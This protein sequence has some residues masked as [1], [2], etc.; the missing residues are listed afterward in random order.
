MSDPVEKSIPYMV[1]T[2]GFSQEHSQYLQRVKREIRWIRF[3]QL[4]ILILAL[5]LWEICANYKLVDPFITSQPS[6]IIATIIRLYEE[7]VLFQHIGITCLEA[8]IGFVLGTLVGTIIAI[9]LWWS[10]FLCKVSEPYL[11]VLNSLPKIALGPVFIVWIGAGPAAII[12]MTLAISLIVTVL[13][14]L[15]GFLAIDQEKTKLVRTFGGTKSQV[16]TKVLLPASAPTIINAL[17]INVGLSWV[18]VIVGEFLVSKAGLGY[19][20][21]YG[22][23]VFKLDLVMSSVIILGVAATVM[24]KGVVYLEK[25]IVNNKA[26]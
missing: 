18:G 3:M 24:Y 11:V 4:L 23:Q 7:G 10:E 25:L 15:N 19:L 13:E 22:G 1:K 2:P 9:I 16:L 26:L 8:V 12:I 5:G 17:K 20:I 21:V 14:I 6:R